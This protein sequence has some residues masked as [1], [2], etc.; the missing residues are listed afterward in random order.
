M[1]HSS[2]TEADDLKQS[3]ALI[4]QANKDM[5]DMLIRKVLQEPK[6][7]SDDSKKA[8]RKAKNRKGKGNG[9]RT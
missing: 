3:I 5:Y 4:N 1:S 9:N 6:D 2:H 8:K 7:S